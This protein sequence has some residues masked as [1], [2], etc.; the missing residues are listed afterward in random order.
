MSGMIGTKV[1]TM[2]HVGTLF[3]HYFRGGST[4]R[5]RVKGYMSKYNISNVFD[6]SD[7]VPN[8]IDVPTVGCLTYSQVEWLGYGT[9]EDFESH[10]W[11]EFWTTRNPHQVH[12]P[13]EPDENS[14]EDDECTAFIAQKKSEVKGAV[15]K[16]R[17][18]I[19][20]GSGAHLVSKRV[21]EL[22]GD[23]DESAFCTFHTAAGKTR[24]LGSARVY[25]PELEGWVIAHV[26]P[27]TPLVLSLGLLVKSGFQLTWRPQRLNKP[28]FTNPEGKRI[29]L[30]LSGMVPYLSSFL[31]SLA[32]TDGR[33]HRQIAFPATI[34]PDTIATPVASPDEQAGRGGS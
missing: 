4:F 24:S 33:D 18:I 14:H 30:K 27:E 31:W 19:D 17:W 6:S 21:A 34:V 23:I 29:P 11:P 12:D 10:S 20:S 7:D 26:L 16:V 13:R 9:P 8:P 32:D 5:R 15:A 3:D 28:M 2:E 22:C 1:G 25:V